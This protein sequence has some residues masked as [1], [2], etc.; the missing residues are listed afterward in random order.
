MFSKRNE[1]FGY[2]VDTCTLQNLLKTE[3]YLP[4]LAFDPS[5]CQYTR[6]PITI[7][8]FFEDPR[9]CEAV[10]DCV[11]NAIEW[12]D[13]NDALNKWLLSNVQNFNASSIIYDN[14]VSW[15][16]A[17][18]VQ[19][20]ID[21]IISTRCTR[22]ENCLLTNG[23]GSW[24]ELFELNGETIYSWTT[25]QTTLISNPNVNT[26]DL[27]MDGAIFSTTQII[28]T[29]VLSIDNTNPAQPWL[30]VTINWLASASLLLTP[31]VSA[32]DVYVSW[33]TYD[34]VS[35]NLVLVDTSG[36]T[37]NVTIDLSEMYFDVT[38]SNTYAT[39]NAQTIATLQ[40]SMT[41][42]IA[43]NRLVFKDKFWNTVVYEAGAVAYRKEFEIQ[44]IP[45]TNVT[46]SSMTFGTTTFGHDA[47]QHD[48]PTIAMPAVPFTAPTWYKRVLDWSVRT[49]WNLSNPNIHG[50]IVF[51]MPPDNTALHSTPMISGITNQHG[52]S[53]VTFQ[54]NHQA[55]IQPW[56]IIRVPNNISPTV[57]NAPL[58]YLNTYVKWNLSL[59]LI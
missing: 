31:L 42:D 36:V 7:S 59:V 58:S 5:Q 8:E 44:I 48:M 18:N 40:N 16:L 23:L 37:P 46:P 32:V 26:L 52:Y 21:E 45:Q 49:E 1:L 33:G 25:H 34:P 14:T 47:Y 35:M 28:N 30:V 13:Y 2:E 55:T 24:V 41:H 10:Q 17:G 39:A 15:L 43:S 6:T 57:S 56:F 20:A 50:E 29:P 19:A 27:L 22:V 3:S 4:V 12:Y 54:I 11:G 9:F 53:Q 51:R 38:P